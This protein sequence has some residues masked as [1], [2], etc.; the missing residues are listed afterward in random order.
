V[1][2]LLML[3]YS[4][5]RVIRIVPLFVACAAILLAD[6][7]AVRWPRRPGKPLIDPSPHD[8]LVAVAIAVVA[9]VAAAW[10]GSFS[11]RCISVETPR[12][13]DAVAVRLLQSAPPGRVVTFF[14]WGEYAIWH[15]GPTL[16]VSMD[17]RRETVY[18]DARLDDHAAIL[19]GTPEGFAT[20]TTWQPE[21]V[22]LPAASSRTREWLAAQGYRIEHQSERSFVAVRPDRPRLQPRPPGDVTAGSCFPN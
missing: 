14:G 13:G 12:A 1:V 17:G 9:L 16:R 20:L 21:Y 5:A 11:L 2:V 10:V 8:G 18:S 22:W 7:T 6:A 4:S 3:A 15:L 19:D